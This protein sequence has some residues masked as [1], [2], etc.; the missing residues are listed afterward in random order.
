MPVPQPVNG[1]PPPPAMPQPHYGASLTMQ[2][3]LDSRVPEDDVYVYPRPVTPPKSYTFPTETPVRPR[4]DTVPAKGQAK[5]SKAPDS[6]KDRATSSPPE[7]P[8]PSAHRRVSSAPISSSSSTPGKDKSG[9][10]VQCSGVTAAGSQCKKNVRVSTARADAGDVFCH[11]HEKKMHEPSG[12]Y[13]RKTGGTFIKFEGN[14]A[15]RFGC[16]EPT[17]I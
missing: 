14:I 12:F 11:L 13:D 2:Y 16:T 10:L 15:A 4:S 17:L 6:T 1:A 7:T 5:S 9:T 8:S 3:A